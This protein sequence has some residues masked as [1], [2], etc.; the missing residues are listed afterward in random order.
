M[1]G[2]S[3]F[4]FTLFLLFTI[5]WLLG[6]EI[7]LHSSVLLQLLSLLSTGINITSVLVQEQT[8]SLSMLYAQCD[9]CQTVTVMGETF[10]WNVYH[11]E[12]FSHRCWWCTLC[13]SSFSTWVVVLLSLTSSVIVYFPFLFT[14]PYI[15]SEGFL[16]F[17][18]FFLYCLFWCDI[19]C[20]IHYRMFYLVYYRR[21]LARHF[22]R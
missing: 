18:T 19:L 20:D 22:W 21:I 13:F 7:F 11:P 4:Q 15:I 9:P 6:F 1:I 10:C 14:F 3:S 8:C 16:S 5:S 12:F 17:I 2:C